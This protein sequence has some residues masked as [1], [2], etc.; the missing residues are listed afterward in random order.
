MT[1]IGRPR[2]KIT[3]VLDLVLVEGGDGVDNDVGETAAEVDDLVHHEGH[4]TGGEGVILHIQVPSSP[5]ALQYIE[6]DIDLGDLF[7]DGKVVD[8]CGRV[9][10]GGDG[11]VEGGERRAP[12]GW[13]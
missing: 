10:P 11:R 6:L 12:R 2:S 1:G 7:E 4:D 3:H 9:E 8:R 13:G 5:E